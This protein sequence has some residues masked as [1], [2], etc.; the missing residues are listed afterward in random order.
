MKM[1]KKQLINFFIKYHNQAHLSTSDLG[2]SYK[3]KM[4]IEE[5]K[6]L[7]NIQDNSDEWLFHFTPVKNAERIF[8]DDFLMPRK[9]SSFQ[10]LEN[11][12]FNY[13]LMSCIETEGHFED[14][15]MRSFI[16]QSLN[17]IE[18]LEE[19]NDPNNS[20]EIIEFQKR[21]FVLD[22]LMDS[23]PKLFLHDNPAFVLNWE[24]HALNIHNKGTVLFC[25]D[26]TKANF[27]KKEFYYEA[28]NKPNFSQIMYYIDEEK[29]DYIKNFVKE[30]AN[31]M[32]YEFVSY[33]PIS[34]NDINLMIFIDNFKV[35][36]I[37]QRI[38][39]GKYEEI[40]CNK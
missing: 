21:I 18:K 7:I 30:R 38:S 22:K 39:E 12:D 1:N 40:T 19:K 2:I 24:Q 31:N 20:N 11:W 26:K 17:H 9:Y 3:Q 29:E 5:I 6:H 33:K 36:N 14:L 10:F 25:I 27:I 23:R 13:D 4:L 16:H 37:I 15:H 8:D 35:T 32:K 28:I 34:V